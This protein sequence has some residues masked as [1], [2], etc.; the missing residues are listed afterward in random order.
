MADNTCA[1][2]TETDCVKPEE[3]KSGASTIELSGIGFGVVT[4]ILSLVI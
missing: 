2:Y 4:A 1:N 3:K